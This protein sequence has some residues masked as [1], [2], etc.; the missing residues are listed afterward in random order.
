[1]TEPSYE[2]LGAWYKDAGP[3][4]GQA[5]A[6]LA[7]IAEVLAKAPPDDP[8]DIDRASKALAVLEDVFENY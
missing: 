5:R 4:W 7:R 3:T 2:D 8:E 1:M 6:M